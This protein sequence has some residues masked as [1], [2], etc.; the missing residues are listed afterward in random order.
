[1]LQ[2]DGLDDVPDR[3]DPHQPVVLH[4]GQMTDTVVGHQSHAVGDRLLRP[5]GDYVSRH[6]DAH[7]QVAGAT[8]QQYDLACVVAF[9]E[10]A[11]DGAFVHDD[12]RSDVVLGH[13][14]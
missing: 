11:D 6:D 1:L 3:D 13:D 8:A 14:L 9:G 4:H 12:Q 2:H 7:R 5:D 10:H